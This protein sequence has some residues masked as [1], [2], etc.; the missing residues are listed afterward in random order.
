MKDICEYNG[1]VYTRKNLK[2]VDKDHFVVPTYLQHILNT[3]SFD[4]DMS[5]L[6]YTE[7][8][9]EGDRYKASES[10]TL[11][12]K[13]YEAAISKTENISGISVVLPRIT[14][15]YRKIGTPRKA[16]ELLSKTKAEHGE[17]FIN[18]V[19]LTSVAAAYC[20]LGEPENA[21]RCCRWAYKNLK[22]KSS[23]AESLE[24]SNVFIRA[25]KMIDPDYSREDD[26]DED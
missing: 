3:L 24:L 15:C 5:A 23:K 8:V 16:I 9:K 14:S 4:E 21:L 18:S 13:Y 10:Y 2:W 17:D 11:A 22:V 20:D 7:V 25:K 12:V 19:L 6:S 1:K 26:F